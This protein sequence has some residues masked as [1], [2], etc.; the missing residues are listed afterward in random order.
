MLRPPTP[1]GLIWISCTSP[2][3]LTRI[4]ALGSIVVVT[5]SASEE[6]DLSG[7]IDEIPDVVLVV[8]G[9]GTIRFAN[10]AAESV[11]GWPPEELVGQDIAVLVPEGKRSSHKGFVKGFFGAP[12]MRAMG[13]RR[14]DGVRKDGRVVPVDVRLAPRDELGDVVAVIRDISTLRQAEQELEDSVLDLAA[15]N[16]RLHE[17]LEH[18]NQLLGVAAHDLRNPLTTIVALTDA[19]LRSNADASGT[20]LRGLETVIESS[21]YMRDLVDDLLA[22]SSLE[23]GSLKLD[24]RQVDLRELVA[25]AGRQLAPI[26]RTKGVQLGVQVPDQL[27]EASVDAAKI[28][29]VVHNLVGNAIKFTPPRGSV[30]VSL[31]EEGGACCLRVVD[32]GPGLS[33]AERERIFLPFERGDSTPAGGGSSTGLGLAIVQRIIDGHG[34]RVGVSSRLGE[35]ATFEVCLPF[36]SESP[37]IADAPARHPDTPGLAVPALA[38]RPA[39]LALVDGLLREAPVACLLVDETGHIATANRRAHAL[40]GY[41]P[42]RLR[43]SPL[44]EL[45]PSAFVQA[46]A[47]LQ[48]DFFRAPRPRSMGSGPVVRGKHATG[49]EL[50]LQVGLGAVEVG[51]QRFVLAVAEDL[52]ERLAAK[53]EAEEAIARLEQGSAADRLVQETELGLVVFAGQDSELLF[54]NPAGRQILAETGAEAVLGLVESGAAGNVRLPGLTRDGATRITEGSVRAMEWNG[55]AARLVQLRDV[56]ARERLHDQLLT[57]EKLGLVGQLA[58][59]VAHDFNNLLT[60]IQ[61]ALELARSEAASPAQ[62]HR[63]AEI[64]RSVEMGAELTSRLLFL[65]RKSVG[66]VGPVDLRSVVTDIEPLMRQLVPKEIALRL[67]VPDD[68][69]AIDGEPTQLEQIVMNLVTNARD[70]CQEEGRSG[71]WIRVRLHALPAGD[72]LSDADRPEP[73][74]GTERVVVEVS[75][76][77]PGIPAELRDRIFEPFFTTRDAGRGTGLGLASVRAVVER[78]RGRIELESEEGVGSCFTVVFPRVLGEECVWSGSSGVA[79][80]GGQRTVLVVDDEP[81]IRQILVEHLRKEGLQ[82]H[83]AATAVEA[84]AL[85]DKL[86]HLDLLVTDLVMPEVDGWTLAERLR[87]RQ[88]ELSVLLMTGYG[89]DV[90][91]SHGVDLDHVQLLS[92]P[93]RLHEAT[94]RILSALEAATRRR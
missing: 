7:L 62:I 11:L 72:P 53:R 84:S 33:D 52:S 68:V 63:L 8:D 3:G 54:A 18:R 77:G 79:P 76:N 35:G 24:R 28:R 83:D 9:T 92:K 45:V 26:A 32:E 38:A 73:D 27:P 90:L 6:I 30:R 25:S 74:R 86:G 51:G 46:H 39:V 91:E 10:A 40:F 37:S 66:A 75:D 88:P 58:S 34:G 31:Q 89:N 64:E 81:A 50:P 14:I 23:T 55:V 49:R 78:A 60:K 85:H 70:A 15:T 4:N 71:A 48:R 41:A 69:L 59:N 56:T 61:G 94:E 16:G 17:I 67:E 47:G 19:L 65:S 5:R 12:Q 1:A 80:L 36:Q 13:L 87:E 22:Y 82:V 43:G 93:F 20:D 2:H 29:Q 21:L 57:I 42:S 44:L